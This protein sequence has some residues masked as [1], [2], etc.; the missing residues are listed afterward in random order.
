VFTPGFNKRA[1]WAAILMRSSAV[2][3]R[4]GLGSS[5]PMRSAGDLTPGFRRPSSTGRRTP[6]APHWSKAGISESAV[7]PR[8]HSSFQSRYTVARVM[9]P[10]RSTS[11]TTGPIPPV[12]YNAS[13]SAMGSK[14]G[15]M[16]AWRC[17][18]W[19]RPASL[20]LS[21]RTSARGSSRSTTERSAASARLLSVPR[22]TGMVA[23][24]AVSRASW[25]LSRGPM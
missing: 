20:S 14:N 21:S 5:A 17:S 19:R 8:T 3:P 4:C 9:S 16:A 24:A 6:G 22:S 15:R 13:E 7:K 2:A 25:P 12:E 10:S 1:M 11:R 18:H 23:P